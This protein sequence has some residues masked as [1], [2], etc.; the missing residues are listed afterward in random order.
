MKYLIIFSLLCFSK[1]IFSQ[2]RSMAEYES[3]LSSISYNFKSN[4]KNGDDWKK[5]SR[6]ISSLIEDA[7][8]DLKSGSGLS[9]QEMNNLRV[10]KKYLD[11]FQVVGQSVNP[12]NNSHFNRRSLRYVQEKVSGV[13]FDYQ[14]SELNVDVYRLKID[15]YLVL[16]FYYS[17]GG[18]TGRK[19]GW[20]LLNEMGC[21]TFMGNLTVLSGVYKQFWNNSECLNKSNFKF[22]V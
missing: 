12:S 9:F 19:I 14:F 7:N 10:I 17:D 15:N 13:S 4:I 6:T 11:A 1:V 16:L 20:K 18:H 21:G 22:K 8:E 3:S 5:A 2:T